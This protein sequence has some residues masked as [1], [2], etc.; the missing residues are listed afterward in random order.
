[1]PRF[2]YPCPDCR[3]RTNLH[4][5][6]CRFDGVEWT[7]IEAA[8]VDVL[9]RLSA[10]S[11]DADALRDDVGEWTGVHAAVLQRLIRDQRVEEREPDE[12]TGASGQETGP[13]SDELRLLTA[14][15]YKE[16]VTHPTMEPLKT[17]YERGS[18]P[19][20][21]DH[22]IFALVAFYEMV[23]LSWEET[24]EQVLTWLTE[25]GTWTRGGFEEDTPEEVVDSKKH[26]YSQGYG[27]K[28]AGKE[29]KAVIERRL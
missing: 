12:S 5:A 18:V 6:A 25:T 8:Y 20:A 3:T 14:A 1:M 7:D 16:R 15:E 10:R 4:D 13:P 23:G 21:H 22:S 17:I 24:R 27:W 26:V 2:E 19:G 28:Q 29:A 9:S 11:W